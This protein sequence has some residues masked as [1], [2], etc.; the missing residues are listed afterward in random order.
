MSV[1]GTLSQ[2][3]RRTPER[4]AVVCDSARV[5][6]RELDRAVLRI[7][8]HLAATVPAGRGVA[9]HLPNG[10]ALVILFLGACRAGREAREWVGSRDTTWPFAFERICEALD[11]DPN[12]IRR[13]VAVPGAVV[14]F[15]VQTY[16]MLRIAG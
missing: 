13:E 12:G 8:S 1:A 9:L 10:P 2:H 3:A 15:P 14:R 11:L 6:W 5:T 4:V 16:E 7:A